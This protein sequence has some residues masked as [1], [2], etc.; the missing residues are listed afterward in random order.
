M[1]TE[2]DPLRVCPPVTWESQAAKL[3]DALCPSRVMR[4]GNRTACSH[5]L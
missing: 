5:G 1:V 3:T 4:G 2:R